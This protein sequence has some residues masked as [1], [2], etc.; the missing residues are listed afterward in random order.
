MLERLGFSSQFTRCI[1]ALCRDPTARIKINGHLTDSLKLF[2]GTQQVCCLSP[3]LFAI[4]IEPL[5]QSIRQ[6]KVLRGI[7]VANEEH[8]IALF[9]DDIIIYL[10]NPNS[11]LPKL[12]ETLEEYGQKSGYKLNLAKTQILSFNYTPNKD[13]RLK[14]KM[15]WEAKSIKYLRVLISQ[16]L[17]KTYEINYKKINDKMQEDIK[18]WSTLRLDFSSRIEAVKMNLM[19]RLLCL[20]LSLPGR[21]L[22]SQF[23]KWDKQLSRFIW[24][25]TR[26]RVRF[27]TLQTDKNHGGLAV[28]NLRQYCYA[29]QMRYFVYWCF[30]EYHAKWKHIELNIDNSQPQTRLGTEEYTDQKGENIIIEDSLKNWYEILKKYK[31]EVLEDSKLLIWPSQ[32][33]HFSPGEIDRTF[34]KWRDK[35]ITAMCT[36]LEGNMFKTFEKLRREFDL[37]NS[38]PFRYLQLRH[39]YE[40]E[41][42]KG[43]SAEGNE[44]IEVFIK[45][46]KCTPAKILSK[47][48]SGLQKRNRKNSLYV[49][50]R[51][52]REMNIT[53]SDSDWHSICTTQQTSTSSKR[54]MKFGWKNLIRFLITSH[55]KNKQIGEQQQ[56]WRQCG[57]MSANHTHIFWSCEKLQGY[58]DRVT[59]TLEDVLSYRIPRDPRIMYLGLTPEGTI[60]KKD[61]YL[62]KILIFASKK[63]ITRNWLKS[64]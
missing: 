41:I 20:F 18:K 11:T 4:F 49:K 23:S 36:L 32:T 25:G 43:I 51:W 27:A 38:D 12:M 13:I 56:C 5:A 9:A 6:N 64:V 42:K 30:P 33:S 10:Q 15:K 52:E 45:A 59:Q 53:L 1:Q 8:L 29:T 46:Y 31:L 28:P 22:D 54:W 61:L 34:I 58:W 55:I 44:I 17:D 48:Y 57:Q 35:G 39:F 60:Q 50:S 21:I 63:A 62:F 24:A 40:T 7:S 3:A 47:M 19:P 2:R 16:K 14:Y 37:D 26:P